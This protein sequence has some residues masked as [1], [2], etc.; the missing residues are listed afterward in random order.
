[1]GKILELF[2]IVSNGP[3]QTLMLLELLSFSWPVNGNRGLPRAQVFDGGHWGKSTRNQVGIRALKLS[4]PRS[5]R[6]LWH[7]RLKAGRCVIFDW[8]QGIACDP[9]DRRA[10]LPTWGSVIEDI[11][12]MICQ[13]QDFT[14]V[15]LEVLYAQDPKGSQL[16]LC[17][18][19]TRSLGQLDPHTRGQHVSL[20]T[21]LQFELRAL[22]ASL[23]LCKFVAMAALVL[24]GIVG[25]CSKVVIRIRVVPSRPPGAVS[26]S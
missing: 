6:R 1:M 9:D 22:V 26:A 11:A 25:C 20:R 16:V 21:W 24:D 17:I 13:V 23:L 3:V 12:Y 19:H 8:A 4:L 10:I 2:P 5:C 7:Q 18:S 15:G 14:V